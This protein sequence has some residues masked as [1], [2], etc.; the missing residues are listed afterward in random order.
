MSKSGKI[1]YERLFPK[2]KKENYSSLK[3]DQDTLTYI[4]TPHTAQQICDIIKKYA[5]DNDIDIK[6][7]VDCTAC[8]G[9]DTI[10][11]A[12]RFDH[13]I[14]IEIDKKRYDMLKNNIDVYNLNNVTLMNDDC[15]SALKIIKRPNVVYIDPPWGGKNY[16]S[17]KKIR[18]SLGNVS[19]EDIVINTLTKKYSEIAPDLIVLKL[20]K[21][22]DILYLFTQINTIECVEIYLHKLRKI[23]V[24]VVV[25]KIPQE[26]HIQIAEHKTC[27][28]DNTNDTNDTNDTTNIENIENIDMI[29]N[30][31]QSMIQIE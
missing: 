12:R 28:I 5:G 1:Y 11:M 31:K 29:E 26:S 2:T 18:L 6:C 30:I 20:P 27:N 3:I 16:K 9:G 10:A 25:N 24:I 15:L 17:I 4:T 8:V 7:I 21:N 22:Y 13:V 14:S 23:N 19:I